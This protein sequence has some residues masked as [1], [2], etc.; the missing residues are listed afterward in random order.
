MD[1]SRQ[2]YDAVLS[3][4]GELAETVFEAQMGLAWLSRIEGDVEG[5][6]ER[7]ARLEGPDAGSEIW[8]MEQVAQAL[9]EAGRDS[10]AEAAWKRL[11][12]RYSGDPDAEVAGFNG[13][14]ALYHARDEF[15][16]ARNLYERVAE[17]AR[18]PSQRDWARLNAA[19][20]RA[21]MGDR[22]DAFFDLD[23]VQ[24]TTM[25]PEVR[26]QAQIVMA[27]VYLDLGRPDQALG[28]LEGVEADDLGPA[29]VA[30]LTQRRVE[31]LLAKGE[32]DEAWEAW[33]RVL[34]R[35]G[36]S[37]DAATPARIAMADL[38]VQRGQPERALE[39]FDEA[40]G[41]TR[42]RFYQAW[43]LLGKAHALAGQGRTEEAVALYERIVE[44]YAEQASMADAAREARTGL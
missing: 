44:D 31:G 40:Y 29:Y 24:K 27:G 32:V 25:D 7:Y 14:A 8:R 4:Y 3:E 21:E 33:G 9:G 1:R 16:A 6:L 42:D 5:A 12:N 10:D 2:A 37:D 19:T 18:D 36:D 15:Q 35:Y 26:L 23:A 38:A 13:L 17:K 41:A 43:S 28:L 39:L 30:S 20:L 11:L 22:E 34:A